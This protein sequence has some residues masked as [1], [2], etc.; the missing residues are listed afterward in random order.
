MA[1]V[2]DLGAF[3]ADFGVPCV[4]GAQ[5]FLALLNQPDELVNLPRA[6]ATSREYLITYRT[7]DV[8]LT[9]GQAVTVGGVDYAVREVPRQVDDGAFTQALL[10]KP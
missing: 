2:E 9:R 4:A 7:A 8:T 5:Q 1:L 6:S 3:L 10:S